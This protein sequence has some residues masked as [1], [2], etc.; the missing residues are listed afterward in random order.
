M[1][2]SPKF[3]CMDRIIAQE[4]SPTINRFKAGLLSMFAVLLSSGCQKKDF[5]PPADIFG[6]WGWISSVG[7]LTGKD[8]IVP[9]ANTQRVYTFTKD[10]T[11]IESIGGQA[12]VPVKFKLQQETSLLDGQQH[13]IL[14]IP[15]RVYV[16][17]PDTGYHIVV[18]R[19][20]VQDMSQNL[21]LA[22]E[23][24]DGYI[25]SYERK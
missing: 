6:Q 12:T 23:K 9:T 20:T 14:T 13:L 5:I 11:F 21:R 2:Y 16:A 18:F 7:G 8:V 15:R 24:P 19:Y 22:Q 17:L 10:S 25:E 4:K 3:T 1:T